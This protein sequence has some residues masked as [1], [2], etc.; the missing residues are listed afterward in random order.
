M[1]SRRFK[2]SIL[3]VAVIVTMGGCS[4]SSP[5]PPEVLA[6]QS[7]GLTVAGATLIPANSLGDASPVVA[8]SSDAQTITGLVPT[9]LEDN[10]QVSTLR[11]I[12]MS[13][14]SVAGVSTPSRMLA[15]AAADHQ[16]AEFAVGGSLVNDHAPVYVIEMAGGPFTATQHPRGAA[17]P[18]GQ[19][20][21]VTIDATSQRVVDVGYVNAEPDLTKVGASVKDILGD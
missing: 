4:V 16:A 20:L 10:N 15:V 8:T 7:A 5:T 21:I 18:Q 3:S 14:S 6:S 12:A 17:T 1:S 19:F 11:G 2:Q 13:A 9:G